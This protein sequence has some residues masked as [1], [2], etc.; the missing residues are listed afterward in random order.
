M[1]LAEASSSW[2]R[3]IKDDSKP[4]FRRAT[5]RFLSENL[6]NPFPSGGVYP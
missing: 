2:S 5:R 3:Q 6:L 4:S 1:L